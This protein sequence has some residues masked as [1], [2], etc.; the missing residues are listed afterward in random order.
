MANSYT[1]WE[2]PPVQSDWSPVIHP[3]LGDQSRHLL[4][5][6]LISQV[7]A[8]RHLGNLGSEQ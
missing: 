5:T 7:V 3:K 1:S 4:T 2:S 8:E 6:L